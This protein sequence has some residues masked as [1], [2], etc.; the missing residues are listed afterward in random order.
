MK[1]KM[2]FMGLFIGFVMVMAAQFVDVV[3]T[4]SYGDYGLT[5]SGDYI[6]YGRQHQTGDTISHVIITDVNGDAILVIENGKI[7]S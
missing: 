7:K 6:R 2:V 5:A 1:M 3:T 4:T